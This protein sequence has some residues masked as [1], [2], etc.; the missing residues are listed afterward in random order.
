MHFFT[1]IKDRVTK[2]SDGY[3][4]STTAVPSRSIDV[5]SSSS[6][7]YFEKKGEINEIKK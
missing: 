2:A 6:H 3:Q 1:A 7:N 4:S 5:P